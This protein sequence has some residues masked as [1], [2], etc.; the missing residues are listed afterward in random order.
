MSRI[1]KQ[2]PTDVQPSIS[3]NILSF[4]HYPFLTMSILF[5]NN[6]CTRCRYIKWTTLYPERINALTSIPYANQHCIYCFLSTLSFRSLIT[7]L[8]PLH[9]FNYHIPTT[10]VHSSYFV[11]ALI[12]TLI[13]NV[14]SLILS[15]R[16]YHLSLPY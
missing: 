10:H 8:K 9:P 12:V 7:F 6:L 14:P 3:L 13:L 5:Q 2:C 4:P 1:V 15:L 11:P 16:Q